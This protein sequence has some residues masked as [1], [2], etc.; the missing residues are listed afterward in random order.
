MISTN[1][2]APFSLRSDPPPRTLLAKLFRK[3]APTD[4]RRA[5]TNRLAKLP[6]ASVGPGEIS[7]D[8]QLYAVRGKQVRDVLLSIWR[9][10]VEHFL[11]DERISNEEATYL[12]DLRRVLGLSDSELRTVEEQ[13][14]HT[15]LKIHVDAAV[16]D[17]YVSPK[18]IERLDALAA[19]LRLPD[20]T[21]QRILDA[22]RKGIVESRVAAAT[23]DQRLS[24]DELADIHA[25]ARGLGV[26][27][28]FDD[29]TKRTFDRLSL[30][31]RVENG[32][33]PTVPV[34]VNLQRT[35]ICHAVASARWLETR[36]RTERINYAGPVASIRI[37]KGLRYRVGSVQVQRI[38]REELTH[39]DDGTVYI[40]NKRLI[41]DGLKKN[42]T[43]R[44]SGILSFTPYSDGVVVEKASGRPVH[45]VLSNTDVE[46]FL[47]IFA[48]A[49]AQSA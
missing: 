28:A 4:A 1:Q 47:A 36:T 48:S 33:L 13:L 15:R 9:E 25:L 44:L 35:E 31:W 38:T 30:L 14:V 46:V 21:A 27:L 20:A 34:P 39:I 6:L 23:S 19:A 17:G 40:T 12:A 24:P 11:S 10:A 16:S 3:S 45:L 43:I 18:E 8:L 32:D 7:T 22:S 37:C 41:F 2:L 5:I 49:L 26:N 42:T 29:N